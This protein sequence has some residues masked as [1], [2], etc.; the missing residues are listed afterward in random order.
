MHYGMKIYPNRSETYLRTYTGIHSYIHTSLYR[1]EKS[2][3]KS[4]TTLRAVRIFSQSHASQIY[5]EKHTGEF[6]K[7]F[8]LILYMGLR[9]L[10]QDLI[11]K[12]TVSRGLML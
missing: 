7:G 3:I 11:C 4:I 6:F 5:T 10:C 12:G 2:K 9:I 1:T 8:L